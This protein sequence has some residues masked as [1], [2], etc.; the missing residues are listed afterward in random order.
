VSVINLNWKKMYSL[1]SILFIISLISYYPS[2]DFSTTL[3]LGKIAIVVFLCYTIFQLNR[4]QTMHV[5]NILRK[6]FYKR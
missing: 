1:F 3:L 2:S 5:V 6:N 4:K